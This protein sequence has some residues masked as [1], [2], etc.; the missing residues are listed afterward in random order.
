MRFYNQKHPSA[1]LLD[2][3]LPDIN[4]LEFCRYVRRSGENNRVPVI[5]VCPVR[6]ADKVTQA[7]EAGAD[8]FLGKPVSA[9]ELR[10]FV[11]SMITQHESGVM[12]LKTKH[13]AGTA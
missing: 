1:V 8:I 12:M 7:I 10:H 11:S 9:R 5:V 3:M 2:V 6:T 4:G 13:L